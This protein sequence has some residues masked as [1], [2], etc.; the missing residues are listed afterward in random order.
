MD[1]LSGDVLK[2]ATIPIIAG[3]I[4]YGTNWVAVRMTFWPLEFVGIRE[5]W[6][7]WQ[8]II[9]ARSKK[10]A[11]IAVDSTL[12][13]L[14]TL[15]EIV[16]EMDPEAIADHLIVHARAMV[17][18]QVEAFA[19]RENP[20]LWQTLPPPVKAAVVAR[21]QAKLPAAAHGLMRDVTD[22]VDQLLDLRMMVIDLLGRRPDLTN[23]MFLEAGAPEFRFIINSG[24]WFGFSLGLVQMGVQIWLDQWWVLPVFGVVVGYLTN[25][26]ALKLIFEPVEPRKVGGVTFHGL[27]LRR[28]EEIAEVYCRLVT[29]EVLTLRNFVEHMLDGPRGDRTR[30]MIDRHVQPI[31]D[32]AFGVVRP[33]ARQVVGRRDYDQMKSELSAQAIEMSLDP[34]DDPVFSEERARMVEET[35]KA[36][37]LDMSS[38]EFSNLLRPAFQEDE[39]T[40]ILV[41]AALGGLAGAAQSLFVF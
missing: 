4:G 13:K 30:A 18:A 40:L 12:S 20:V 28:Q 9:P 37:M 26:L 27:F 33:L 8:G 10:M 31:V 22:H 2:F 11:A 14:G 34:L 19:M 15:S 32:E 36:R 3:V 38:E 5:P 24:A 21:V 39:L 1:W 35:M 16:E 17:P 25:W 29:R 41:G 7:G 23:R 6:L